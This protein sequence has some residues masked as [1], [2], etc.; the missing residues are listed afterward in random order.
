MARH[1][2]FRTQTQRLLVCGSLSGASDPRIAQPCGKRCD[3]ESTHCGGC[4]FY[5]IVPSCNLRSGLA[6]A[7]SSCCSKLQYH[8]HQHRLRRP[9][10]LGTSMHQLRH[11]QLLMISLDLQLRAFAWWSLTP[12]CLLAL[13]TPPYAWASTQYN[14]CSITNSQVLFD[15]QLSIQLHIQ[16][17]LFWSFHS[18]CCLIFFF[19]F[20]FNSRECCLILIFFNS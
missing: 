12:R 5:P 20:F 18:K 15:L 2:L 16:L 3:K 8:S 9:I 6:A 13:P 4:G 19:L 10:L 17:P 11:L 14:M 1:E 7:A